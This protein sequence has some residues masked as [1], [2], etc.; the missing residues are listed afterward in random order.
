MSVTSAWKI[1]RVFV[2]PIRGNRP[3]ETV[4]LLHK[5]KSRAHEGDR[6]AQ[7]PESTLCTAQWS[8]VWVW[9]GCIS[10]WKGTV[11][12]EAGR[13]HSSRGKELAIKGLT[14]C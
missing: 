3:Q 8:P 7:W 6:L 10:S 12:R 13:F 4:L 5:E 14:A 9:R 1:T 11:Q 2:N